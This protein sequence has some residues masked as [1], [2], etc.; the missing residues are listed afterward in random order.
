VKGDQKP[1]S[2]TVAGGDPPASYVF[3]PF[4]LEVA[5]RRLWRNGQV[6]PVTPKGFDT[7]LAMVTQAGRV[8]EKDDLLKIVWPGTFVSEE[9][10]TQNISTLR[11]ALGDTSENPEYIA[12]IPRR[13][14][15][16]IGTLRETAARDPAAFVENR[17][18]SSEET[19]A[20]AAPS[21]MRRRRLRIALTATAIVISLALGVA[22]LRRPDPAP[23]AAELVDLIVA[24]PEGTTFAA[25][26]NLLAVSPNGQRL[27]F[28]AADQ[29]GVTRLWLRNL[30]VASPRVLEGTEYATQPFWSADGSSIAFVVRGK[31][32]RI[33]LDT[34]RVREICDGEF[35]GTWSPRGVILFAPGRDSGIFRVSAEGGK[36]VQVTSLDASLK[37]TDHLWPEFLPDGAHFLY[38]AKSGIRGQSAIYATTVDEPRTRVRLMSSDS[39]AAYAWPGYLLFKQGDAL[40]AR[41]FDAD[42]FRLTGEPVPV[43]ERVIYNAGTGRLPVSTSRTGVLVLAYRTRTDNELVWVDR[44]GGRLER[45]GSPGPYTNPALTSDG[46]RLAVGRLDARAGTEDIW[47]FDMA[48]GGIATRLTFDPAED[49]QP[50]WS[51]DG[52]RLLFNSNR[53]GQFDFYELTSNAL[54]DER[55]VFATPYRKAPL[56]WSR[57]GR[58]LLYYSAE[59]TSYDNLWVLPLVGPRVPRQLFRTE[60]TGS[61]AEFTPD[62]RWLAYMTKESGADSEVFIQSFPATGQKWQIS[63][64]GGSEPHWRGDGRELFYLAPNNTLMSVTIQSAAATPTIGAQRPLFQ[65]HARANIG[66]TNRKRYAVA[67]DG[68]RFLFNVPVDGSAG[69]PVHVVVNWPLMLRGSGG[70]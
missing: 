18:A 23:S 63:S 47:V 66:G 39:S 33:D 59:N 2:V 8:V 38:F 15:Q 50:V 25:T 68:Q 20:K 58:S 35:G 19:F 60:G 51:P 26:G 69:S 6:V 70:S 67:P 56:D 29:R 22:Y 34:G 49:T 5:K 65:T 42:G 52:S 27:A 16:F 41:P 48:R 44:S 1:A 14:Y 4:R 12:T 64:G 55:L 53:N 37:E 21:W 45:V 7:L 46:L 24:P 61:S 13:G 3:G 9:T 40:V 31:L 30:G 62:G 32:R 28:L 43:A 11:K 10:L 17:A 54:G 57:D 36:P